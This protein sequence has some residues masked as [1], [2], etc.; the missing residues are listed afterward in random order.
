MGL[1]CYTEAT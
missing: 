1:T